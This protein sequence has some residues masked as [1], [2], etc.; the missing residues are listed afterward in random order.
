MVA[1][2]FP[3]QVLEDDTFSQWESPLV[4]EGFV[5]AICHGPLREVYV[6]NSERVLVVCSEHGNICD[7]GRVTPATVSIEI[8]RSIK[9]YYGAVIA[10]AD[11]W[12]DLLERGFTREHAIKF[13]KGYVC[14]VC[15]HHLAAALKGV[16]AE[17]YAVICPSH[18]HIDICGHIKEQDFRYDFERIKKFDREHRKNFK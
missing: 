1:T 6:P 7:C 13:T 17:T 10:L 16:G 12:P 14:A 18:G 9:N 8:E 3:I 15:G 2:E 4:V 11:L 5:C